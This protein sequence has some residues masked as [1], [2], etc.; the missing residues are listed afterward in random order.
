MKNVMT[1]TS[2][3]T[4]SVDPTDTATIVE[5]DIVGVELSS[6]GYP[7]STAANAAI[8]SYKQTGIDGAVFDMA[9]RTSLFVVSQLK[10]F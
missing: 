10:T 2:T 6:D 8:R 5:V 7:A 1:A 4:L 9:Q 3:T